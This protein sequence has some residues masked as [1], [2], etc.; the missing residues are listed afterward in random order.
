MALVQGAGIGAGLPEVT[1][2]TGVDIGGAGEAVRV[3]GGGDEM[4]VIRH[5]M[6]P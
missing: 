2:G 4:D 3:V 5:G 1:R 6:R